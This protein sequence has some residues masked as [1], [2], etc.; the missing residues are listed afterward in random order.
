VSS[1]AA[2]PRHV[3]DSIVAVPAV[4]RT[5]SGKK[6]GSAG[7]ADPRRRPVDAVASPQLARR[8]ERARLVRGVRGNAGEQPEACGARTRMAGVPMT[9]SETVGCARPGN[10]APARGGRIASGGEHGAIAVQDRRRQPPCAQGVPSCR[11]GRLDAPSK[12]RTGCAN[13]ACRRPSLRGRAGRR[14]HATR[15]R[16]GARA[17]GPTASSTPTR[18]RC[19]RAGCAPR[20]RASGWRVAGAL[21]GA[22][23]RGDRSC[24]RR[25]SRSRRCR[26]NAAR[27]LT[28][29]SRWATT[30]PRR[31]SGA[32]TRCTAT[33]T[34]ATCWRVGR[35]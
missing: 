32:P 7:E 5:L 18:A 8:P 21:G 28:R 33:G 22:L 3:P 11:Y 30:P 23:Q 14:C 6:L 13:V 31:C 29:S 24:L 27:L 19:S 25:T 12:W 16:N 10:R 17:R 35:S 1:A 9:G 26:C 34:T 20:L 4:P 15:C 2:L